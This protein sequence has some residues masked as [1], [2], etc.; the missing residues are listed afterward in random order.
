[1]TR[2]PY[3]YVSQQLDKM[4]EKSFQETDPADIEA[5]N[6]SCDFIREFINS[7]GW[8]E[9]DYIRVMMGYDT[10]ESLNAN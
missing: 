3:T 5:V 8:S 6:K 4:Y 2:L 7:C 9:E 10:E 1:M